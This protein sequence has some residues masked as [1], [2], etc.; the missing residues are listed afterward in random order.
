MF[1]YIVYFTNI[2][3]NIFC[4]ISFINLFFLFLF[5]FFKE[6]FFFTVYCFKLLIFSVLCFAILQPLSGDF[7]RYL[8]RLLVSCK[9][10]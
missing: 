5:F 6:Y 1:N 4:I 9:I 10:L 8:K 3:L 7:Y 2:F